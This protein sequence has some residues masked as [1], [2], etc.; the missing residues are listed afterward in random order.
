[1]T[2][3]AAVAILA[4]GCGSAAKPLKRRPAA[5]RSSSVAPV[6]AGS[7]YL[8][9]GDSYTF[10]YLEYQVIPHPN[11]ADPAG[12]VGYPEQLGAELHLVVANASCPGETSASLISFSAHSNGCENSIG[13]A[14]NGYRLVHP[15]HVRYRGSQLAYAVSYL[16]AHPDVRLVSLMIGLND[17]LLCMKSTK[18]RCTSPAEWDG[19]LRQVTADIRQILGAIRTQG[20]YRGEL[21]IVNYPSPLIAYNTHV[22]TL[23]K[24]IDAAASPFG[25]IVADGFGEFQA[26]D[27][28]SG[29]SPCSAGLLTRL[30]R[31][32][33]C[34]IHPSYAGQ[35]L[36]AQALEQ[37][38]RL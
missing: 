9:L 19:V 29:G 4:G 7:R 13:N 16:N 8:A 32:G 33:P 15:L 26:A 20:H 25:V 17:W 37:V 24:A 34:G 21:A 18:D 35:A 1:V 30:G 10:G 31:H 12:F 38:I 27:S 23:N 28:H 22:V 3:L 2:A 6:V 36:L 11:Y 14:H 5:A